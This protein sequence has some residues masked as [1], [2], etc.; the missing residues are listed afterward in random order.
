MNKDR[1]YFEQHS[2]GQFLYQS[3]RISKLTNSLISASDA[4]TNF[5]PYADFSQVKY[6]GE[7][8]YLVSKIFVRMIHN[9]DEFMSGK[10]YYLM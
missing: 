10:K 5:Q 4:S 7:N 9:A 1:L 3:D 2:K 8:H 6:S